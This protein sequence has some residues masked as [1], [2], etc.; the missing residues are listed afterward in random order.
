MI[1]IN[2]NPSKTE[3][4][5]FGVL[6]LIFFGIFGF[7]VWHK[8][9]SMTGA[10]IIWL[11]ALIATAIYYAIPALRRPAY[12]GWMY[13]V[14]PIGWTVSHVLIAIVFYGVLTPLG[15]IMRLLGRDPLE[16]TLDK[17]A[18]TYWIA[19]DSGAD[20]DRYFRQF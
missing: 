20:P 6:G 4:A 2:K 11:C 9:H 10:R 19:H 12:L 5:W 3:L 17:S 15:L 1:E 18:A 8:T 7:V 14:Y 13:A 16:R